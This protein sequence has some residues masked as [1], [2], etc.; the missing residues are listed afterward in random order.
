MRLTV[1]SIL[2]AITIS[3][4]ESEKEMTDAELI[5]GTWENIVIC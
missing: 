2:L 1:E 3:G 5:V 4:C